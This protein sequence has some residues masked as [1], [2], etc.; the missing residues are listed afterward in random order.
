M[1]INTESSG[2]IEIITESPAG[3]RA[4]GSA[5]GASAEPGDF[6]GL[7]G[8]LGAGKTVLVSGIAGGLGYDGPVTSPTF[9]LMREYHGGRLPLYHIDFYRINIS[10]ELAALDLEE[11]ALTGVTAAEW[12]SRFPDATGL[13]RI[14]VAIEWLEE[15]IRRFVVAADEKFINKLKS[16]MQRH[17]RAS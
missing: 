8:D 17:G 9:Q 11:Y 10:G 3:T 12:C 14:M 15:N 5:I 1:I 7:D 13:R 4:L 6:I 2:S 16:E